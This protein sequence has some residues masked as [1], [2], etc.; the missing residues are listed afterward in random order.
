MKGDFSHGIQVFS[1]QRLFAILRPEKAHSW[2]QSIRNFLPEFYL[3]TARAYQPATP[4]RP[5]ASGV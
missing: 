3:G 4:L 1:H 5:K 2:A